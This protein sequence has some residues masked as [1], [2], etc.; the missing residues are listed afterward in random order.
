MIKQ[1]N[2]LKTD[3]KKLYWEMGK[4]LIKIKEPP[5]IKVEKF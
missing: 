1:N 5:S 3:A 4:Q 2:T